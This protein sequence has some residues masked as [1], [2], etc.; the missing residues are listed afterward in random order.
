MCNPVPESKF[1]PFQERRAAQLALGWEVEVQIE[2]ETL[3][4]AIRDSEGRLVRPM[5]LD[6]LFGRSTHVMED[7]T[8]VFRTTAD[9]Y[10]APVQADDGRWDLRLTALSVDGVEFRRRVAI[11]DG[12]G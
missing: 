2:G 10:T 5:E 1:V 11:S 8:L 9:G 3:H 12:Q 6:G 7:Q 4:L